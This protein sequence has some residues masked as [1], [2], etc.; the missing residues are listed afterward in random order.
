MAVTVKLPATP[1]VKV[2][3]LALVMAGAAVARVYRQRKALG[4]ISAHA[5][6]RG[7]RD[8]M[9]VAGPHGRGAASTPVLA[10]KVTPEGS[11]PVS[12]S[13]D[14]GKPVAVTVNV[15]AAPP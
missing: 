7:E 13:V 9:E 15:P 1:T 2:V 6:G 14:V 11:V 4:G 10:L 12:L 5:V 3:L 8:G